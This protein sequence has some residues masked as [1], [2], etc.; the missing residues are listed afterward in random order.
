MDTLVY[1]FGAAGVLWIVGFG[2]GMAAGFV[3]RL[4]DAL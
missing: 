1:S 3:R 4:R 2:F